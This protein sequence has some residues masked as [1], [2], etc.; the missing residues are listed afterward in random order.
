VGLPSPFPVV[1]DSTLIGA[2]GL[3]LVMIEGGRPMVSPLT[4]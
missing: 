3:Y 1:G 4:R 2:A